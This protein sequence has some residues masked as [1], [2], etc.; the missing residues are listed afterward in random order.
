MQSARG[1]GATCTVLVRQM[2]VAEGRGGGGGGV[3]THEGGRILLRPVSLHT[4]Y[5]LNPKT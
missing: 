5:T 4:P 1:G 2:T 3:T